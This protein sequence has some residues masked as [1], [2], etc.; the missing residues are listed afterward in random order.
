MWT[1]QPSHEGTLNRKT[2]SAD[3]RKMHHNC[4]YMH[5]NS[6]QLIYTASQRHRPISPQTLFLQG[7]NGKI[8]L[9]YMAQ[10]MLH[11]FCHLTKKE[12]PDEYVHH[13]KTSPYK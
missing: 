1:S 7:Y 8:V 9:W 6:A 12:Q 2:D 10:I 3:P 4:A 11:A 5:H 13:H